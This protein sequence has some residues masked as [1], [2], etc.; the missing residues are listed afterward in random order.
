M[1]FMFNRCTPLRNINLSNFKTKNNI[2]MNIMFFGC[3]SLKRNKVITND[4][5]ILYKLKY[6]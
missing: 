1:N 4:N 6:Y 2:N 3:V 5:N